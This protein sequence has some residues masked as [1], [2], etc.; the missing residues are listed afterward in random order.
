MNRSICV[1]EFIKEVG[2][3]EMEVDGKNSR[4]VQTIILQYATW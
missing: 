3:P 1:Q 2:I 4:E